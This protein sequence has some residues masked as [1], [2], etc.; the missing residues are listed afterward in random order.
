MRVNVRQ[1]NLSLNPFYL[2]TLLKLRYLCIWQFFETQTLWFCTVYR[3]KRWNVG[4]YKS[5]VFEALGYL[6]HH[7]AR[8]RSSCMLSQF[9]SAVVTSNKIWAPKFNTKFSKM[10]KNYKQN[11]SVAHLFFK[12]YVE[13]VCNWSFLLMTWDKMLFGNYLKGG[14]QQMRK[15]LYRLE[16]P[17]LANIIDMLDV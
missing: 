4:M 5:L 1:G 13:V 12:T 14:W 16:L 8:W 9:C 10:S 6:M 11:L 15:R 7:I 3:S 17:I 2:E